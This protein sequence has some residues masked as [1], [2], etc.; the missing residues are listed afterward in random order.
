MVST[1]VVPCSHFPKTQCVVYELRG[2]G[3]LEYQLVAT[4]RTK[5]P[6]RPVSVSA[7]TSATAVRRM[8]VVRVLTFQYL[9]PHWP[10]FPIYSQITLPAIVNNTAFH[11]IYIYY[12]L[13]S[14]FYYFKKNYMYLR[15][16]QNLDSVNRG[17][18]TNVL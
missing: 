3:T 7:Q 5:A 13:Y 14:L 4:V 12:L 15:L 1:N 16:I 10:S 11:C 2:V 8:I 17:K 6:A 9:R 18:S